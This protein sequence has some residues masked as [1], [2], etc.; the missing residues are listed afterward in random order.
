MSSVIIGSI[1]IEINVFDNE[2]GLDFVKLYVDDVE[3]KNFSADDSF[4]W[5]WDERTFE[6]HIIKVTASDKIGNIAE[7]SMTVWKFF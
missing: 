2:S 7:Y 1:N 5:R 3:K 4:V 6:K